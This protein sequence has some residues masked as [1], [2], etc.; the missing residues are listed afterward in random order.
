[1][2]VVAI[3]ASVL[4]APPADPGYC[5]GKAF[6][7]GEER[8]VGARMQSFGTMQINAQYLAKGEREID[9][10]TPFERWLARRSGRDVARALPTRPIRHLERRIEHG[11]KESEGR[12]SY[13]PVNVNV[14]LGA[15]FLDTARC[16]FIYLGRISL[17]TVPGSYSGKLIGDWT[18]RAAGSN[19]TFL[20]FQSKN[21]L[22][23]LTCGPRVEIVKANQSSRFSGHD[24]LPERCEKFA[25][26]IDT[27]L[28]RL[29]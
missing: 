18:A 14:R 3:L 20:V 16:G 19:E 26:E 9:D 22:V 21:A 13:W 8:R 10:L 27:Q 17:A 5:T 6:D 28:R 29:P 2:S 11:R 25:R 23:R 24:R 15:T 12:L 7:Q 4:I 1:M